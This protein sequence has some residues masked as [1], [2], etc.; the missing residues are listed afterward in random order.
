MADNEIICAVDSLF[1]NYSPEREKLVLSLIKHRVPTRLYYSR[2]NKFYQITPCVNAET[3]NANYDYGE[4]LI[5]L[6]SLIHGAYGNKLTNMQKLQLLCNPYISR[7]YYKTQ[8]A[9]DN[10]YQSTYELI[11]LLNAINRDVIKLTDEN[12]NMAH[13]HDTTESETETLRKSCADI[14]NKYNQLMQEHEAIKHKNK[15][16]NAIQC[17]NNQLKASVR[18]LLQQKKDND[19][20]LASINNKID[21]LTREY[22]RVCIENSR[23]EYELKVIKSYVSQISIEQDN[24]KPKNKHEKEYKKSFKNIFKR[25]HHS[26]SDKNDSNKQP[27]LE[28]VVNEPNNASKDIVIDNDASNDSVINNDA[29]NDSVINNDVIERNSIAFC[30][31]ECI[32]QPTTIAESVNYLTNERTENGNN[33]PLTTTTKSGH[34]ISIEIHRRR[35]LLN[36]HNLNAQ[37]IV[38]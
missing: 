32:E 17:E 19:N 34:I 30:G 27:V 31:T 14:T 11:K 7:K 24:N 29:N 13:K 26:K 36:L 18:T 21:E 35:P 9:P 16:F 1:N 8:Y 15:S 10:Y 28:Q 23:L 25:N 22:E 3:S 37:T 20:K 4:I 2:Y 33:N 6:V 12:R 38:N 5:N